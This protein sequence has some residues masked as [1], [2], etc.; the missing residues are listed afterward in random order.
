VR[1]ISEAALAVVD[2]LVT[3]DGWPMASAPLSA[4]EPVGRYASLYGRD[5]VITALQVL[6]QRPGIAAATLRALGDR[7]GHG[8]DP[9]TGEEPGKILHEDW[10]E[11][12]SWHR[13][14]AWPVTSGGALRYFGSVD[15]TPLYLILAA[16]TGNRGPAVEAALQWLRQS[17]SRAGLLTYTGHRVGGLFHQGWR[18]GILGKPGV[19]ICW[20]DG[21]QVEPPIAVASAQAFAYEALR[22]HGLLSEAEALA[23]QVDEG[24]FRHGAP[25]PALAVDGHGDAVPTMASE[26]GILLWSGILRPERI[27]SSV[28]ALASLCC[29]WGLRTISPRHLCFEATAYHLGAVWPFESWLAWGGLRGVGAHWLATAIRKGVLDAV[30]HLGCWPEC[31]GVPLDG[32]VPILLKRATRVQAWTAGAVWAFVHEWDGR[33]DGVSISGR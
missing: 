19:G 25:W 1:S 7:Q 2:T 5:F 32:S 12:P 18:D 30:A 10:V 8:T 11:A 23:A 29:R 33:D 21:S 28:A 20:P 6:P 13:R 17:L 15:A 14:H 31:Y 27:G 24:F 26:I 16:R 4:D 3:S 22:S 9:V